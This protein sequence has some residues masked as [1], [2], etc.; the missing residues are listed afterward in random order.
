M[1]NATAQRVAAMP[2]RKPVVSVCASCR[3][4]EW[5]Q[6][7]NGRRHP[8]GSGKCTFEFPDSPLPLWV[9][10]HTGFGKTQRELTTVREVL[11]QKLSGRFINWI[12][13]HRTV[14]TPCAT[15]E[16]K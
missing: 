15:W 14:Q 6:T 8:E 7:A 12:E 1:D 16:A 10:E 2:Q 9:R 5:K 4:A 3:F 11:A 13:H